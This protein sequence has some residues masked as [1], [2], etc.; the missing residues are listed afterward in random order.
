MAVAGVR[1]LDTDA[2]ASTGLRPSER[3]PRPIDTPGD[4]RRSVGRVGDHTENRRPRHACAAL[5][6][7]AAAHVLAP[8]RPPRRCRLSPRAHRFASAPAWFRRCSHCAHNALASTG[9]PVHPR[10]GN[11]PLGW[12]RTVVQPTRAR[13][14]VYATARGRAEHAIAAIDVLP[15]TPESLPLSVTP[16]TPL[17]VW[18]GVV[19]SRNPLWP[20][21][22]SLART[23]IQGLPA[24]SE[25]EEFLA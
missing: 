10:P 16:C 6:P 8:D 5:H 18:P 23:P 25:G 20:S 4:S 22:P 21:T 11:P 9:K 17:R 1:D 24:R 7:D 15:L 19:P 2:V 12:T 13:R 14:A 3:G